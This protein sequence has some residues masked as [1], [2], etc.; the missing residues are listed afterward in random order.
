MTLP[1]ACRLCILDQLLGV[2]GKVGEEREGKERRRHEGGGYRDER[3]YR[4]RRGRG[5]GLTF[6]VTKQPPARDGEKNGRLN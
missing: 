6:V 2:N 5:E 1:S 3:N 4:E